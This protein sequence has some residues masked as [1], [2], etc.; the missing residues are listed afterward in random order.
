MVNLP[1]SERLMTIP[2]V[3]E[4][5]GKAGSGK[6]GH[7]RNNEGENVMGRS[8]NKMRN[9]IKVR[10]TAY[11]MHVYFGSKPKSV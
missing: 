10:F 5:R 7:V 4:K 3:C 11:P 2:M 9:E 1:K 8:L 6:G